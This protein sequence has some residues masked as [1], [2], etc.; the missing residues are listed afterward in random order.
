MAGT[1]PQHYRGDGQTTCDVAMRSMMSFEENED[2]YL[3][4]KGTFDVYRKMTPMVFVWWGKALKY[5]WR[6]PRKNG[7]KDIDK[8]IDSLM[9]LKEEAYGD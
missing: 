8:A 4:R 6:W 2:N 7:E 5:I 3:Y 9:R 1:V